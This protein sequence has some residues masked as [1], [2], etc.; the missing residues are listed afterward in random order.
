MHHA[1]VRAPG[2][3]RS[4]LFYDDVVVRI[5]ADVA[6]NIQCFFDDVT[7]LEVG[8]AQQGEGSRL[9]KRPAR[10]NG[11]QVIFGLDDIPV[12]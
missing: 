2:V 9:G 8:V 10:A 7:C 1:L 12:A 6:G 11:H 4:E 3:I 5:H